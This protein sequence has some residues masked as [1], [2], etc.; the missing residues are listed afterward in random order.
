MPRE[1]SIIPAAGEAEN[2]TY[3]I[4]QSMVGCH[5]LY[6]HNWLG[7]EPRSR[8]EQRTTTYQMMMTWMYCQRSA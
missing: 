5:I 2:N 7:R 1:L 8:G 3:N 6:I 4:T